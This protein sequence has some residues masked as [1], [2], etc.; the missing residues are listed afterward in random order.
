MDISGENR[1]ANN[2]PSNRDKRGDSVEDATEGA[3]QSEATNATFIAQTMFPLTHRIWQQANYQSTSGEI[4]FGSRYGG[5]KEELE[6]VDRT[7]HNT[8]RLRGGAEINN[9]PVF[10]DDEGP[11][12]DELDALAAIETQRIQIAEV[13]NSI[14]LLGEANQEL[15]RQLASFM[16]EDVIALE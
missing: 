11:D 4:S 8:M 16:S 6:P 1:S 14:L 10:S 7:V 13:E 12:E 3:Q 5:Q 2:H 9:D 15:D